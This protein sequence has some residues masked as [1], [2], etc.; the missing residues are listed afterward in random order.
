MSSQIPSAALGP[1]DLFMLN[2]ILTSAG[3]RGTEAEVDAHSLSDAARF[4]VDLFQSGVKE[5]HDLIIALNKRGAGL[6]DGDSTPVQIKNEAIDRWRDE[7]G[8]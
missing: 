6:G 3:F 1:T 2:G 8:S 5:E 7:G 4:L